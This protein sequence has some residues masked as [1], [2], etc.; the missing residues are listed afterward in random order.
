[1]DSITFKLEN[2]NFEGPLDLLLKLIEKHKIDIYNIPIAELTDSYLQY[3]GLLKEVNADNLSE[4][5]LMAAT[6]L[7][8]KSRMLLPVPEDD[9]E[10]EGDPREELVRRLLEYKQF[11]EAAEE[12]DVRQKEGLFPVF[13][14]PDNDVKKEALKGADE[15]KDISDILNGV[16]ADMLYKAF[17][18][19]MKR[20]EVRVDKIRSSFD[21]VVK[22]PFTIEEKTEHIKNVLSVKNEIE[23]TELFGKRAGK[24]ETVVTFMALLE[25]IKGKYLEAF[26]DTIFGRII[27]RRKETAADEAQ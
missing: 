19:V 25:L 9:E 4:F 16:T 12:L 11:K 10:G 17:L 6:L 23:F 21:S 26:Q 15:E 13:K 22:D 18:D 7:E 2:L 24:S 8:I 3:L 20:K 14:A 1:M 27:I 5:I